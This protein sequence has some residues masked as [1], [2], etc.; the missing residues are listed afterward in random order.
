[1]TGLVSCNNDQQIFKGIFANNLALL[2]HAIPDRPYYNYLRDNALSAYNY[3]R[4][5]SDFYDLH[6]TGPFHNSTIS[7]QASA[8]SL[9]VAVI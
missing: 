1:M 8:V 6:W 3:A 9:W 4:N 7:K 5:A 2:N